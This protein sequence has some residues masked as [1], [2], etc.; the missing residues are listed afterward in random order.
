MRSSVLNELRGGYGVDDDRF[1]KKLIEDKIHDRRASLINQ[2]WK[3]NKKLDI[4]FYQTDC[5]ISVT[6]EEV[7][8][9]GVSLGIY[10]YVA[11]IPEVMDVGGDHAIKFFG[12]SDRQT[13]FDRIDLL[14]LKAKSTRLFTADNPSY[15]QISPTKVIITDPPRGGMHEKV[16]ESI[17]SAT[18]RKIVYISCNPATQARD[19][20]LLAELYHVENIQPV[21]MFP[22]TSHIENV[23]LLIKK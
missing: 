1:D 9:D 7:V 20:N 14:A 16:V 23:A 5:C 4:G 11:T 18:P 12:L 10:E 15:T 6:C 19:I 22:Q 3:E 2:Y 13:W 17:L 21:D 8:C